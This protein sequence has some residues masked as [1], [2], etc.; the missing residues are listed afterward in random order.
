MRWGARAF[1]LPR[2]R[3]KAPG[4]GCGSWLLQHRHA[5]C[6]ALDGVVDLSLQDRPKR[7][8]E[9]SVLSGLPGG[10]ERLG[11]HDGSQEVRHHLGAW[12]GWWRRADGEAPGWRRGNPDPQRRWAAGEPQRRFQVR[13]LAV[14]PGVD[15]CRG[16]DLQPRRAPCPARDARAVAW[17]VEDDDAELAAVQRRAGAAGQR[18]VKRVGVVGREHDGGMTVLA[19]EVVGQVRATPCCARSRPRASRSCSASRAAR[20]CRPTTRSPAARRSATCWR[21]TSRAPATWPR[22]TRA[23]TAGSASPSPPPGPGA[24][25]LVTPIADAWMDS[26]P[27]VC[28]TGQVRSNLIGTDA[29]QECDITGITIPIVKHSWLVQRRRGAAAR[30]QGGVPLAASGRCGPVLVD[31][32]RDVQEAELDFAYPDEVDAARPAPPPRR[33][34]AAVPRGRA[35]DRRGG[36][37][38]PLRRRRAINADAPAALRRSPRRPAAR[39]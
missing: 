1:P 39:S 3:V 22:A 5:E 20:S 29:F 38:R 14:N 33:C 31:V 8:G 28:V 2:E 16:I 9:V 11:G 7:F 10:M 21:A 37:A 32:P 4:P 27:L 6:P 36:A 18:A 13:R 30:D 24:T 35:R 23:R 15:W 25:N 34:T 17:G 12:P 26:T 19:A